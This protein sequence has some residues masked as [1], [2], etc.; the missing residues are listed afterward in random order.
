MEPAY[1]TLLSRLRALGIRPENRSETEL[2]TI[3]DAYLEGLVQHDH[4]NVLSTSPQKNV[5]MTSAMLKWRNSSRHLSHV[6][7]PKCEDSCRT[8]ERSHQI[9]DLRSLR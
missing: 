7:V 3:W 8:G 6:R 9:G 4:H 1:A 5:R 2:A